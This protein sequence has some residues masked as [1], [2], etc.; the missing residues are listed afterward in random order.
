[1]LGFGLETIE[2]QVSSVAHR[3]AFVAFFLL[4]FNSVLTAVYVETLIRPIL[5]L[6]RFMKSAGTGDL[7]VRAARSRGDEVGELAEAF[8][9][10]M[11]E[12]EEVSDREK[13]QRAQL[14]HTE[15]MA[16]VGTLAAGVAHEVNN[17]LA[18][19]LACIENLRKMG[20]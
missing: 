15:K 6:N 14:A 5:N 13:I 19:V 18:G 3:A 16:A 7:S 11:D 8:N 1:M 17:P 12:L 4:L 20:V 2:K 10:M 9:R